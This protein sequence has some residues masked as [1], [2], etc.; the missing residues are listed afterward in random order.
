VRR[1]VYQEFFHSIFYCLYK[2]ICNLGRHIRIL[3]VYTFV[4]P[5]EDTLEDTDSGNTYLCEQ[6]EKPGGEKFNVNVSM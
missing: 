6:K 2:C 3:L 1:K 4:G 5:I